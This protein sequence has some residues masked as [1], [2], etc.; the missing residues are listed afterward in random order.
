MTR[1]T[2]RQL[3]QSLHKAGR[4]QDEIADTLGIA[5]S[6]VGDWL[7]IGHAN[8]LYGSAEAQNDYARRFRGVLRFRT[9]E[10]ARESVARIDALYREFVEGGDRRGVHQAQLM[11]LIGKNRSEG[12]GQLEA[13]RLFRIWLITHMEPING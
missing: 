7:E 13:A 1:L 2:K 9:A 11:A 6:I 3:A 12:I 4:T 5:P 10:A 8:D